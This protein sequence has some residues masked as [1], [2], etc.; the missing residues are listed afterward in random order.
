[1]QKLRRI[2]ILAALFNIWSLGLSAVRAHADSLV[3]RQNLADEILSDDVPRVIVA[4]ADFDGGDWKVEL[5]SETGGSLEGWRAEILPGTVQWVRAYGLLLIPRARL[6]VSVAGGIGLQVS[7][8]GFAQAGIPDESSG[9]VV[10]E[11]PV[12]LVSGKSNTIAVTAKTKDGVR[13]ANAVIRF[14]P[15]PETTRKLNGN[16][17]FVNTS[18]SHYGVKGELIQPKEDQWVYVGC[19]LV[20]VKGTAHRTSH[21]ETYV[22]WDNLDEAAYLGEVEIKPT[23]PSLF[24]L[25]LRH[26]PG[27]VELRTST[28]AKLNLTYWIPEKL[29]HLRFAFGLGGYSM[30][31]AGPTGS[32]TALTPLPTLYFNY[33]FDDI[34]RIVAFDISAFW[35]RAYTD[36]GLYLLSQQFKLIDRRLWLSVLI[37]GHTLFFDPGDRLRASFSLPQGVEIGFLDFFKQGYDLIAGGFIYPPIDSRIYYNVWL[38]W[39]SPHIFYELNYIYWQEPT[40]LGAVN[41]KNIGVSIGFPVASFL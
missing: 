21:L 13:R 16:R 36:F 19:R 23:I 11:F 3:L 4:P 2:A 22:F 18:C 26:A 30:D 27:Q 38:R 28:G 20:H 35:P 25:A 24:Q 9:S 32:A 8:G 31:Y 5:T 17:V 40:S 15:R 10:A 14:S 12:A 39:G 41:V 29:G 7:R 34:Y 6:R 33:F 1:M 37:G